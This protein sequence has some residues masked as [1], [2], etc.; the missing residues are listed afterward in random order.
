M[1]KNQSL[2][3]FCLILCTFVLAGCGANIDR[4]VTFYADE[5]WQADMEVTF[6]IEAIALFGSLEQFDSEI[7]SEVAKWEGQG[8]KVS[9][10]SLQEETILIY[11]FDIEGTG[12]DLLNEIVFENRAAIDADEE[13]T[14]QIHFSYFASSDVLSANQNMLTLNGGQIISSNGNPVKSGQVQWVNPSGRVEA[15]LTAK[16]GFSFVTILIIGLVLVAIVAGFWFYWQKSN[17]Q[18]TPASPV[19]SAPAFCPNCG[20]QLPPQGKFCPTCGN[21]L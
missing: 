13:N 8:A 2:V 4:T 17:Q 14:D 9:W 6:P 21:K 5:R 20:T 1:Q 16:R 12:W 3:L 15:V 10:K 19:S 11:T 18:K 7:T